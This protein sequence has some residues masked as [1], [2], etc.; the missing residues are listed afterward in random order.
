MKILEIVKFN[1]HYAYVVDEDTPLVY[2]EETVPDKV[3]GKRFM[4][5]GENS[6]G[7]MSFLTFQRHS[8]RFKA[9]AGREFQVQ[10]EDGTVRTLKD[11]WWDG[12]S[13]EWAQAHGVRICG[14]TYRTLDHLVDC[15]VFCGSYAR[16]DK[17]QA[18]L[19]EFKSGHPDYTPWEYNDWHDHCREIKEATYD[20]C[21][22]CRCCG[23]DLGATCPKCGH[24]TIKLKDFHNT[25]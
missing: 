24:T 6:I 22:K 16:A 2:H 25:I 15:C 23:K 19:D 18:L 10:M 20:I 3:Y 11:D 4:L 5:V 17:L 21:P 12:G 7:R 1:D 8:G 13:S 9:F 14:L